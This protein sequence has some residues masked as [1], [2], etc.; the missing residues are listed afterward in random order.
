VIR[1]KKILYP[2][3]FSSYSN[4]AYF[5]AIALAKTHGASLTALFV[6]HPDGIMT[7][8]SQGDEQADRRYW[9]EQLEQIRPVDP[10]IP[11]SHVLLQG[12]PATE[13]VR[14]GRDVGA[15]LI[16]MGTHGRTGLDR[17]LMGSVAEKVLRDAA[18]SV[19]VVKLPRGMPAIERGDVEVAASPR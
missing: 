7:P 15:D 13:I 9:Q 3:D 4:Q 18:C 16:V 6:Y 19:L 12:D 14:Y 17:L 2:T 5:H 10:Q 11:V 8:G 1:I